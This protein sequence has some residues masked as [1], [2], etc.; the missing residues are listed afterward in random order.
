MVNQMVYYPIQGVF[1][2]LTTDGSVYLVKRKVS[3]QAVGP[4]SNLTDSPV[5]QRNP[6]RMAGRVLPLLRRHPRDLRLYDF[7]QPPALSA[8][9][10][11][12]QVGPPSTVANEKQHRRSLLLWKGR[13]GG[14]QEPR[15]QCRFTG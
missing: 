13:P 11:H 10:R 5:S 2:W 8:S 12:A 9:R 15:H 3:L 14:T 4:I 7:H 6:V 1:A